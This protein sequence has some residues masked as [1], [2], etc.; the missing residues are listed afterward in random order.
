MLHQFDKEKILTFQLYLQNSQIYICFCLCLC[1][2]VDFLSSRNES[3]SFCSLFLH[4][5]VNHVHA[6]LIMQTFGNVQL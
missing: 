4:I 6:G 5:F 2:S 1:R 3:S